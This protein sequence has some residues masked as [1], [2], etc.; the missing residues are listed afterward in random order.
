[1]YAQRPRWGGHNEVVGW[2]PTL[3]PNVANNKWSFN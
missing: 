2:N 1:M 3:T